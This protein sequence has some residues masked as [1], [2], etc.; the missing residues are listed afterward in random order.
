MKVPNRAREYRN[1]AE[2]GRARATTIEDDSGRRMLLETA[3]TWERMANYEE[4]IFPT[5]SN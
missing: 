4:K 2:E 3:E 1:R 5:S